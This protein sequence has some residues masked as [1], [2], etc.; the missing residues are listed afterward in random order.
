MSEFY[1][2]NDTGHGHAELALGGLAIRPGSEEVVTVVYDPDDFNTQG[3]ERY[4]TLT[5]ALS[6]GGTIRIATTTT[7]VGKANGLGDTEL[8]CDPLPIQIGNYV[9]ID[10]DEDGVQDACEDPVEG[11][12][13]K[14]YTKPQ[15]GNAEL[16]ATTTT[17]ANGEYYFSSPDDT[18]ETWESGFTEI[19]EGDAYFIVFMG[20]SYNEMT[21]EITVGTTPYTLTVQQIRVRAIIPIST[22][23]MLPRW[24][25]LAWA[26]CP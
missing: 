24:M 4:S 26:I 25:F 22:I 14:L 8:F 1:R 15:S 2:R 12:I 17:N 9:W 21:D 18:D 11:L 13:V 10:E 19:V 5:G 3:V 16:V 6:S 7:T 23:P 20:D